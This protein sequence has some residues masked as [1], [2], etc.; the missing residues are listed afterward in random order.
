L[1]FYQLCTFFKVI[2]G[3]IVLIL[4]VHTSRIRKQGM[5]WPRNQGI[6]SNFPRLMERR[7][8]IKD[9]VNKS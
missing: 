3:K 7:L 8:G 9:K 5:Q 1:V 4:D 2:I 6:H